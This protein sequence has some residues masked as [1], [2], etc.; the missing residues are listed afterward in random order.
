MK[1]LLPL[2]LLTIP[3]L[4]AAA[5]DC[6]VDGLKYNIHRVPGEKFVMVAPPDEGNTVFPTDGFKVSLGEHPDNWPLVKD[7]RKSYG[8][9]EITIPN[10]ITIEGET[11]RVRGFDQGA[12]MHEPLLERIILPE[13][14]YI[15][16]YDYNLLDCPNLTEITNISA[17]KMV[18][19]GCFVNVPQLCYE[20]DYE[21][22]KSTTLHITK[23]MG[24]YSYR[25]CGYEAIEL[26]KDIN[27]LWDG[28]FSNMPNLKSFDIS[29]TAIFQIGKDVLCDCPLLE[30][31]DFRN[32]DHMGPWSIDSSFKNNPS[33]KRVFFEESM[34]CEHFPLTLYGDAF[35]GC[36]ALEEIHVDRGRIVID[37][38]PF[39]GGEISRHA[40][41]FTM[42]GGH[43][44][45]SSHPAWS[46]IKRI[47]EVPYNMTGITAPDY[48]ITETGT[49]YL[50]VEWKPVAGA[51]GY[52][53]TIMENRG[54]F[55]IGP[56]EI[57]FSDRTLPDAWIANN[58]AWTDD[59]EKCSGTAPSFLLEKSGD[60]IDITACQ[61]YSG[62]NAYNQIS[63][64][65]FKARPDGR[66]AELHV[67]AI[68][69]SH[70][71]LIRVYYLSN[72]FTDH[73]TQEISIN[74]VGE[75]DLPFQAEYFRLEL[76]APEGVTAT[77]DDVSC[78]YSSMLMTISGTEHFT[79]IG[80]VT[81]HTFRNL[82]PAHRYYILITSLKEDGQQ[83]MVAC[84]PLVRTLSAPTAIKETESGDRAEP[85]L[86]D[87]GTVYDL[88]GRAVMQNA[89]RAE[90]AGRLSPG[91]YL[92]NGSKFIVR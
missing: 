38:P 1:K 21:G 29:H 27:E 23:E 31:I 82:K 54:S 84:A 78:T 17:I 6:E 3:L 90:A 9:K 50:T 39:A 47:V 67:Y 55:I 87:K 34:E 32:N 26:G 8:L 52:Y 51:D 76:A 58:P 36:P 42:K 53:Y 20:A 68:N 14:G 79:P 59:P 12:I 64:V 2:L 11:Y 22:N 65:N 35:H 63:T 44:A 13:N 92:H 88:F 18:G 4:Q 71:D 61:D 70:K 25:N 62:D 77:I 24:Y 75:E 15:N 30:E 73:E 5:Y 91:I 86:T 69:G 80:N 57:D 33:L 7:G 19:N 37:A 16:L 45:Y 60:Y 49:D 72:Y 89:T 66:Y 41:L 46:F 40:T 83:Y 81:S 43:G 74:C 56:T 28:C 85:A 10:S 48:C